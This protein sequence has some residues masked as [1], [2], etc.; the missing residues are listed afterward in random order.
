[1]MLD[2][3]DS[4]YLVLDLFNELHSDFQ[5]PETFVAFRSDAKQCSADCLLAHLPK[6]FDQNFAIPQL[7][8]ASRSKINEENF[9]KTR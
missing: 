7:D 5:I 9:Y 1:M 4:M 3:F 2:D 6:L 8:E